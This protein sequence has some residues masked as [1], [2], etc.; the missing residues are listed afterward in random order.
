MIADFFGSGEKK[1]IAVQMSKLGIGIYNIVCL[2]KNG[3]TFRHVFA[4]MPFFSCIF[5]GRHQVEPH[6]KFYIA[7]AHMQCAS[8]DIGMF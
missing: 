2:L 6:R 3:T 1:E 8:R 5:N 4:V 7:H